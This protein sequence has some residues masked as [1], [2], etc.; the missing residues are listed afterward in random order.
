MFGRPWRAAGIRSSAAAE[1]VWSPLLAEFGLA[2]KPQAARALSTR[3]ALLCGAD[4]KSPLFYQPGSLGAREL[5]VL[6]DAKP[7]GDLG[8]RLDH[9]A[10][11]FAEA[12]LVHLV[13]GL[14]VP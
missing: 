11:V 9:P 4:L 3:A 7:A 8:V 6:D 12:V 5:V 13:V 14:D 2:D 1:R 10:E